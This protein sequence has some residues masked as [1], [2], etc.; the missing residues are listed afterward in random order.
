MASSRAAVALAERQK[1]VYAAVGVHP[2][3]G[4]S[5]E[6]GTRQALAE[7]AQHIGRGGLPASVPFFRNDDEA[8][9]V[10]RLAGRSPL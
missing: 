5:W 4:T 9:L 10:A 8:H 3:Y 6:P 1:I 2:N 7:L